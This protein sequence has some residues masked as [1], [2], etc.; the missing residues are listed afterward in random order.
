MKPSSDLRHQFRVEAAL[1]TSCGR[2][3]PAVYEVI[4]DK[5]ADVLFNVLLAV[6]EVHLATAGSLSAT[7]VSASSAAPSAVDL[8]SSPSKSP[9]KASPTSAIVL[10]STKG[11]VQRSSPTTWLTNARTSQFV[12]GVGRDQSEDVAFTVL[13]QNSTLLR[14]VRSSSIA[15]AP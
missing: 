7:A 10:P 8:G 5:L 13:F 11:W 2:K 6:G 12:H 15:P 4:S 1:L 14:Y 3:V 9:S